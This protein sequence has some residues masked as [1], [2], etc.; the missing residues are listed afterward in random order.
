MADVEH[1]DMFLSDILANFDPDPVLRPKQYAALNAVYF[2]A[3]DLIVNL[4][5]GYGKSVISYLLP[6][7][8]GRTK[9]IQTPVC[10]IIF[11]CLPFKIFHGPPPKLFHLF[12]LECVSS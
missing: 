7:I 12:L 3:T 11:Y 4:P 10:F 9:Q 2:G 8:L 6:D 1:F 5:V